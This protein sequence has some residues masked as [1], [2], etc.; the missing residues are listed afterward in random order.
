MKLHFHPFTLQLRHTFTTNHGQRDTQKT[1][2]VE[3]SDGTHR[4]YG[5]AAATSY[6]G[7]TVEGMMEELEKIRPLIE[8]GGGLTPDELWERCAPHLQQNS[9]ALCALDIA[10]HDLYGKRMGLPLYKLWGLELTYIP[11]TNYTIGIDTIENMVKKMLEFPWPLYKIK[12]GTRDDVKIV[13]EL[14]KHT[15]A[16]FRVDANGAWTVEETLLNA[17]QFRDLRVEFIEQPL[18]A[19]DCEGMKRLFNK[20]TLPLIADESCITEADVKKCYGLFDGVNIKLVKCGGITPALRMIREARSLGLKVMVGCMTES[21]V[22]I[23][24]IAQL[25]PLLDYVDMDGALLLKEDIAE[26]V[27]IQEG[28]VY[29]PNRNGTGVVLLPH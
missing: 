20:S 24:A 28:Q 8:A 6:Y 15:D 27:H 17:R 1:L 23:S 22:G 29:F 5:E 16:L 18:P 7:V 19:H 3:L 11:M 21:T 14:R 10:M 12:L 13:Q 2:V 9:F 4:G 26:G 25:L